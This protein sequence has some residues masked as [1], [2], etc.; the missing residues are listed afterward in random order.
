MREVLL[1]TLVLTVPAVPALLIGLSEPEP[2]EIG[3]QP[4]LPRLSASAM[5]GKADFRAT[6]A[7]C[8]GTLG[9]GSPNGP[10]LLHPTY[11]RPAYTDAAFRAAVRSGR[12][13]RH[14]SF[15]P[16]P[17]YPEMPEQDLD[18][19]VLFVRELQAATGF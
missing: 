5:T 8:H 10:S 19:I 15:G 11:A 7:D 3:F 2:E 9:Q 1:A 14:W 4:G 6:C 18:R 13:E 17:A 16:M 12:P